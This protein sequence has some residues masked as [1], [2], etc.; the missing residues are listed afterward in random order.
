MPFIKYKKYTGKGHSGMNDFYTKN[1]KI[2]LREIK[3]TYK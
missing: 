1:G 2:L 3:T